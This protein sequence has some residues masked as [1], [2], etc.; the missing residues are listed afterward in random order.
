MK[1]DTPT[2]TTSQVVLRL[3]A[4]LG[5]LRSWADFLS[6]NI[7]GRQSLNGLTLMPAA[8][9]ED[10]RTLRPVYAVH[11][12]DEFIKIV[13]SEVPSAGPAKIVPKILAIEKGWS[14]RVSK[15]DREGVAI[16]LSAVRFVKTKHAHHAH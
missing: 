8:R 11:D 1:I 9:V 14:W 12:V 10:A 16:K 6:D 13:L 7:R 4:E 3:Y 2:L 5:T 15:F